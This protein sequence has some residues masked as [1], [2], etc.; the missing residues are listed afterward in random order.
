MTI[1]FNLH[2]TLSTS[3]NAQLTKAVT[4]DE[5]N[6]STEALAAYDKAIGLLNN[7]L[8]AF[9]STSSS[10][11]SLS[12]EERSV[13]KE[14]RDRVISYLKNARQRRK[15]LDH[16][17]STT[18]KQPSTHQG[19]F[20]SNSLYRPP[21]ISRGISVFNPIRPNSPR[22]ISKPPVPTQQ[23]NDPLRLT[24]ESDILD[25]SP[26][27]Q[28]DDIYGL[29]EVKTALNEMVVLPAQRPDLYS[30]LRAPGK[31]ILLFGPPGTGKTLIAKA[32]ATNIKATF[33]SISAS[34]LNSKYHGESER[35]V[36]TLFQ[37]ARERQ[38]SFIFIDEV[39]SILGARSDNEHEASRRLKTE[40]MTQ[41]D[42]ATSNS[43]ANDHV[44][45]MAASNRPQDLDDA[46]RRRLDRRIY[47]PLPDAAG[48]FAFL[49]KLTAKNVAVKWNLSV[50]DMKMLARRMTY[51]SGSDIKALCREASLMP[52][53]ELGAQ[54]SDVRAEDVRA[55][56][57][58]D[59]EQALLIVRPSSN[60]LQIAELERWNDQF[61][62][63]SHSSRFGCSDSTPRPRQPDYNDGGGVVSTPERRKTI[64]MSSAIKGNSAN[65]QSQ[66]VLPRAHSGCTI[67]GDWFYS[68]FR[69]KPRY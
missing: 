42:G 24:I 67:D 43:E 51:F 61:G 31:G 3:A 64:S 2:N 52:L 47:V 29:S 37:V 15:A 12:S 40:F 44:Y 20:N 16:S 53:R 58:K 36:R 59:F 65:T 1:A 21:D 45:V 23:P 39:D 19:V 68:L 22:S 13:V 6:R 62:S 66:R 41:F 55:C 60:T 26:N 54:V 69:S 57:I 25:A 10:F 30:G 35:L 18:G 14:R 27:V 46:V 49:Q 5:Q 9:A 56:G 4:L 48:R 63:K 17:S 8:Q 28:W 33:F 50:A 7:Y 11:K 32:V 38:P 34:S